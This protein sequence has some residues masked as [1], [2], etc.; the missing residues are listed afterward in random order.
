VAEQRRTAPTPLGGTR[1]CPAAPKSLTLGA[2]AL[3]LPAADG[4]AEPDAAAAEPTPR[5]V[6]G[7]PMAEDIDALDP[8]PLRRE[9]SRA[10]GRISDLMKARDTALSG[11]DAA[12]AEAR[13]GARSTAAA[14][15]GAAEASPA[16]SSTMS[17]PAKTSPLLDPDLRAARR[18]AIEA[19]YAEQLD[20]ARRRLARLLA[21]QARIDPDAPDQRRLSDPVGAGVTG[22]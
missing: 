11:L 22:L 5:P 4:A 1:R 19:R 20:D 2:L 12:I 21:R 15:S 3:L 6:P 16:E 13:A 9:I 17:R 14:G 18:R 7:I 10:E 8:I